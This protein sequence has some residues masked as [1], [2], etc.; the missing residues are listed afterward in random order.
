MKIVITD[1]IEISSKHRQALLNLGNTVIYDDIPK[2][3]EI[4]K[5]IHGADIITANWIDITNNIIEQTPTLKYIVVPAVG[6]EWIDV[7]SANQHGITVT[8]CPT[9]NSWAVAEHTI[10]L[11]FAV[12]HRTIESNKD[13]RNGVWPAGKYKGSELRGKKLGLIGYGHI[14]Q[15][16][17]LLA[18][19][20]GMIVHYVNSKSSKRK[21][22]KIFSNSDFISIHIPLTSNTVHLIKEHHLGLMQSSS[23][24]VNTSRGAIIDQKYLIRILKQNKIAGA[25]LDV[26]ENEPMTGKL[27]AEI[28]ELAILSNVTATPH[29]AY[30]TKESA[31]RLGKELLVNIKACLIGKPINIIN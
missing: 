29:I 8:N 18:K 17:A 6:Y 24:I 27:N 22:D 2:E 3:K 26:F 4:I 7:K 13:L 10:G 15:K 12:A 11:M 28:I 21:M 31:E 5:R 1:N 25:A 20:L 19:G 16:V 30:N 23:Y 14:G 9:F